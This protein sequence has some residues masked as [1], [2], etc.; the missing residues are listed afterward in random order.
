MKS[1]FTREYFETRLFDNWSE[2]R[3]AFD[4]I[5]FKLG[6]DSFIR[7]TINEGESS[8]ITLGPAPNLHRGVGITTIQIFVPDGSG[9]TQIRTWADQL[10]A[11][12]KSQ[13]E[14]SGQAS[15]TTLSPHARRV[16]TDSDG[17]YQMNVNVPFRYE[18]FF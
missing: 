6:E 2:T 3:I 16:G 9:T 17:W 8:Q 18:D 5:N 13:K 4:N 14:T 11:L 7:L 15:V 12:F 10:I 1:E